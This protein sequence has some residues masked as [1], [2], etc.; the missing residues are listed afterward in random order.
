MRRATGE[1]HKLLEQA[2]L[3]ILSAKP[4]SALK[5]LERFEQWL[6]SSPDISTKDAETLQSGLVTLHS[7]AE[8]GVKGV[9]NARETLFDIHQDT[10]TVTFYHKD[11]HPVTVR[12]PT[13]AERTAY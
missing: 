8:A 4:V 5:N 13:Q 12:N 1:A 6:R 2:R 9:R 7:L 3:D 10:R 11:G